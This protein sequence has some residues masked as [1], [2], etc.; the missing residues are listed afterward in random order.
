M[1]R[2]RRKFRK[3]PPSDRPRPAISLRNF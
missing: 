3:P 1:L 2:C